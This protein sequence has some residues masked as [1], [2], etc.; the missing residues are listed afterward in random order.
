MMLSSI[1]WKSIK[2]SLIPHFYC[3]NSRTFSRGSRSQEGCPMAIHRGVIL[4]LYTFLQEFTTFS[5]FSH[6]CYKN[7]GDKHELSF[8]IKISGLM[9]NPKLIMIH[10]P[11]IGPRPSTLDLMPHYPATVLT[12]SKS[13]LPLCFF[14]LFFASPPF[15]WSK[16]L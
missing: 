7:W 6:K 15:E 10:E 9:V 13:C 8:Y 11:W 12:F 16:S 2:S 3:F 5:L 4:Y 14:I 1:I